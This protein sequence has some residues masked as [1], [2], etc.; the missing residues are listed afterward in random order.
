MEFMDY[1]NDDDV[2][3]LQ[4]HNEM[5]IYQVDDYTYDND[6]DNAQDR[7]LTTSKSRM[8]HVGAYKDDDNVYDND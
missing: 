3:D 6:N 7:V 8:Y 1:D 5:K 2:A 4:Q